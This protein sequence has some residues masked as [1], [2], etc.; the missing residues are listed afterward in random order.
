MQTKLLL[1]LGERRHDNGLLELLG[2][3]EGNWVGHE[4]K[5]IG[6]SEVLCALLFAAHISV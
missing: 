6:F 1:T 3:M 2:G 4:S 5:T